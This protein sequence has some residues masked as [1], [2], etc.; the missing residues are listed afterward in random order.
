MRIINQQ[1]RSFSYIHSST[2]FYLK[3][4]L[5]VEHTCRSADVNLAEIHA[6]ISGLLCKKVNV[7]IE[8]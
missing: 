4:N 8:Y 5:Q 1:C 6:E 7:Q 2:C 3:V